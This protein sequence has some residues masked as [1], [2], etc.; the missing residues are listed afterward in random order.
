MLYLYNFSGNFIVFKCS[1]EDKYLFDKFGWWIGWFF[2]D[3]WEV[4]DKKG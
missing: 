1:C 3:D 2:W 4:V